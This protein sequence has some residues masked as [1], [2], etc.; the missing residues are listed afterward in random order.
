M[1]ANSFRSRNIDDADWSVHPYYSE[2][3]VLLLD[4]ITR[5]LQ[6]LFQGIHPSN[7][8][9]ELRLNRNGSPL[10]ECLCWGAGVNMP[11]QM[12]GF[13]LPDKGIRGQAPPE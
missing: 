13:R 5:I 11:S 1:S 2:T 4:L 3:L 10:P 7:I 6:V 9:Q 12:T 8:I